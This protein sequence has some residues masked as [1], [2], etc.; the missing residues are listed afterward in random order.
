MVIKIFLIKIELIGWKLP[1]INVTILIIIWLT[2]INSN[3]IKLWYYHNLITIRK[4]G[5]ENSVREEEKWWGCY[6]GE[7]KEEGARVR[8]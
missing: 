7:V 5:E 2:F 1:F 6:D 4:G 3:Q 8:V